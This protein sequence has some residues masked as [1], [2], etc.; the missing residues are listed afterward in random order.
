MVGL[1][2]CARW[3]RPNDD[4]S[5]GS[6]VVELYLTATP[7]QK[8]RGTIPHY[9]IEPIVGPYSRSNVNCSWWSQPKV[10]R[11]GRV[12]G[13]LHHAL[14]DLFRLV[15]R[16]AAQRRFVDHGAHLHL[17]DATVDLGAMQVM[18][19]NVPCN[20]GMCPEARRM[21]AS[22]STWHI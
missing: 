18:S 9:V 3:S 13:D 22:K 6:E 4:R 11:I 2:E 19:D 20:T 7:A 12:R 5:Y 14:A 17:V 10:L 15:F 1:L 16:A 8:E 21:P